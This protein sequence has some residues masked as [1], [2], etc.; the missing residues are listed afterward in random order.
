MAWARLRRA[1]GAKERGPIEPGQALTA[2]EALAGYTTDAAETV[3]EGHISGR[4]A[5]GFR[6][7]LAAFAADPV[8]CDADELPELPVLLTVVDGQVVYRAER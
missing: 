5:E 8:Q 3:S 4:I 1:G 2:L 7:D 6:G